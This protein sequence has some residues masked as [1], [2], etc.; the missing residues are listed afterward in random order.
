MADCPKCKKKIPFYHIGQ[1]CPHCGVNVRFYDFDKR[2]YHDAKEAELSNAKISVFI[3]KLKASLIGG[4]LPI[5][6][7]C[8]LILPLAALVAP[9]ANI[10]FS[11]PFGEDTFAVSGLGIFFAVQGGYMDVVTSMLNTTYNGSVFKALLFPLF[12]Y[13]VIVL[14]VLTILILTIICFASIKK[15]PKALCVLSV[16]GVAASV[17]TVFLTKNLSSKAALCAEGIITSAKA[18]A[19][20]VAP[21]VAFAAVFAINFLIIKKGLNLEFKEGDL[22]R[23]AIAKKVK[24]GEINIDDLPQPIV[25]TAETRAID[26]EIAK[27]QATYRAKEEAAL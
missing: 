13:V 9:F 19:G 18:S 12:S 24:A 8:I 20:C 16:I 6:R 4:P 2:F 5:A 15:M 17:A 7:L 21:I 23:V 10:T 26:E 3:A 1:N 14:C 25:E 11:V 22:E 27:Q